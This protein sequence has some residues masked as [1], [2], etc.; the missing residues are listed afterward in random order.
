MRAFR[1]SSG[2]VLSLTPLLAGCGA[3]APYVTKGEEKQTAVVK[4]KDCTADPDSA[5]VKNK[6]PLH[7]EVDKKDPATY[8]VIFTPDNPIQGATPVM[9]AKL[10][11]F[12]RPVKGG[13]GCSSITPKLCGKFPYTL[14]Q[15]LPDVS[16]PCPDPGVHVVP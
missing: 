14:T 12:P 7:W 2:L 3:G 15:V 5:I 8:I 11:D 4:I 1:I 9:S 13:F 16:K 10:M 6:T